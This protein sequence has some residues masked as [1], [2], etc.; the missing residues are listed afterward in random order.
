MFDVL[1]RVIA[2][3]LRKHRVS[4]NEIQDF[5]SQI[6]ERR[7][8]DLFANFKATVNVMEERKNGEILKLIKLIC[9]KLEKGKDLATILDELE[10]LKRAIEA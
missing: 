9:K 7:M 2:V 6:K 1:A 3:L 5:V 8:S 10:K 4:E